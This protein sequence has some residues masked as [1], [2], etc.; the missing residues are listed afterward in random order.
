MFHGLAATEADAAAYALNAGTDME[1]VSRLY[2][3][4]GAELVRE[5]KLSMAVI[6]ESVRRILRIKYRLGLFDHPYSDA[7]LEK[8]EV[9]KAA[10]RSDAK[11]AAERSFVLLKNDRQ[12]LPINKNT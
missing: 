4:H 8:R 7:E 11:K 12:T 10:Y 1:M 2:N 5:N 6:D 9:G 3:Q